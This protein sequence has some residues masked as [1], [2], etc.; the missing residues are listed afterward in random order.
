LLRIIVRH[1]HHPKLSLI[2]DF[3][4]DLILCFVILVFVSA[5]SSATIVVLVLQTKRQIQDLDSTLRNHPAQPATTLDDAVAINQQLAGLSTKVDKMAGD[6]SVSIS[7]IQDMVN[8]LNAMLRSYRS[9]GPPPDKGRT[10]KSRQDAQTPPTK[11]GD[12]MGA[13]LL[14]SLPVDIDTLLKSLTRD[15]YIFLWCL[16][17]ALRQYGKNVGDNRRVA[18][19]DLEK[20][21]P[22]LYQGS[23]EQ[24]ENA[25]R[26]L[27]LFFKEKGPQDFNGFLEIYRPP[28]VG[29]AISM[30]LE[31][32]NKLNHHFLKAQ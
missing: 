26:D 3:K 28:D 11:Q 22:P 13:P 31:L 6:L 10:S 8:S 14:E 18:I 12:V 20:E 30:K 19:T 32:F 16:I 1:Q 17:R 7:D 25:V 5:V 2:K 15:L 29:D 9:P 23:K 24:I 27:I 4:D 21:L